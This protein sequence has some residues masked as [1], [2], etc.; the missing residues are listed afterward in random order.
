MPDMAD[1]NSNTGII[2]GL[3]RELGFDLCGIADVIGLRGDF[4]LPDALKG[5]FQFAVSLA[6][7]LN[8]AVVE[9]IPDH[10]TQLYFH[11]YRQANFFL[12][13]G[14]FILADRIQSS[15][16]RSLAIP[17][18]QVIDWENQRGHLSHKLVGRAAGLGWIGRNNL[19]VNEKLGARFRLVTILTDMQLVPDPRSTGSCG[20]CRACIESCPAGAIKDSAAGYDHLACYEKL[21]AFRSAGY[22][23]QFIC[24]VCVKAC[25]PG[26]FG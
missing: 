19:L 1:A 22:V 20:D 24:G 23:S 26:R 6:K 12:D 18:S 10:P 21:K 4:D 5:S 3:A 7:R 25:R 16:G 8:D 17:A 14:A 15:G 9:D 11:H 2:K 13:R